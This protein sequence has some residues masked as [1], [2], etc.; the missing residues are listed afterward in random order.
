MAEEKQS[1]TFLFDVFDTY[2]LW[3][4]L[5]RHLARLPE[6]KL[7]ELGFDE[8]SIKLLRIT[9]KK[10]FADTYQVTTEML[11]K[12]DAD[13]KAEQAIK[14]HWRRWAKKKTPNV[15]GKLYEKIM[16]EGDA[17]RIKVWQAFV[18][19]QAD[20]LD[21]DAGLSQIYKNMQADGDQEAK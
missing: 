15:I 11:R 1:D 5:P 21:I 8:D 9:T 12:W 17:A 13:P 7:Q 3:L 2:C 10:L 6:E 20:K 18:E 4:S 19:Q 16:E 14:D